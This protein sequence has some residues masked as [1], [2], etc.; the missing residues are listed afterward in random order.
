MRLTYVVF[1]LLLLALMMSVQ[2]QQTAKDFLDEGNGL[3]KQ[4]K[5]DEAIKAYDEA[6]RLDPKNVYAWNKKGL[7]LYL[8]GVTMDICYNINTT[9]PES[10]LEYSSSC[11]T[12]SSKL[13]EAI[14]AFDETIKLDPKNVTAWNNKGKAFNRLNRNDEAIKAYDEAIRLNPKDAYVW[15][16]KGSALDFLGRTAEADAAFARA[17]KLGYA[18]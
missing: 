7:A 16:N 6:I 12:I 8:M 3:G 5:Y 14:E 17:K 2:C 18:Y 10:P 13:N 4:G 11:E 9:G 15:N 1:I